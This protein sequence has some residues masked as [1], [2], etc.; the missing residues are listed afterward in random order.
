LVKVILQKTA[1]QPRTD[2]SVVFAGGASV[3]CHVGTLA[4]HGECD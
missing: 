3:P 2:S 4:P 1:S